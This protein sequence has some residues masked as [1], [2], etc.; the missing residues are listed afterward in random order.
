[1]IGRPSLAMTTEDFI[2]FFFDMQ[3][4]DESLT[5]YNSQNVDLLPV[6]GSALYV[7]KVVTLLT[8]GVYKMCCRKCIEFARKYG[9]LF[10]DIPITERKGFYLT[11]MVN[12]EL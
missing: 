11:F 10:L 2:V 1:M 9:G 5:I 4:K 3:V 7:N 12:K 6:E 8:D